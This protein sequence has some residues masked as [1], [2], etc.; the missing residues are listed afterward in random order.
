MSRHRAP[1]CRRPGYSSPSWLA[2][3]RF[4]SVEEHPG[5][6]RLP[7]SSESGQETLHDFA[8]LRFTSVEEHPG[9][10]RLPWSSES[11]QEALQD[12]ARLLLAVALQGRK[13][14]H[15]DTIA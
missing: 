9:R 5:R 6:L 12:F 10:L 3:L 2:S 14:L 13:L 8:R 15:G 1:I 11:G 7:W 4:T